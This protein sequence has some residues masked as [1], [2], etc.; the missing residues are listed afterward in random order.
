MPTINPTLVP[1]IAPGSLFDKLT[2]DDTFNIRWLTN[3]DP[4]FFGVLNRP[5]ADTVLRTLILAKAI[6]QLNVSLGHSAFFPFLIQPR[7]A[8]GSGDVD[9]PFNWLWDI[10]MS[11]PAKWANVRL[12]K[13]KR[14][15][16]SNE[17]SS[18][19]TGRL[20]L[21]FT[22][23]QT[24]STTETALVYV[25]YDI[26]SSRTYQIVRVAPVGVNEEATHIEENEFDTVT[27]FVT[28]K[29]LDTSDTIVQN[30][31]NL[32]EPPL[33]TDDLDNN[34]FF[35]SPAVYELVDA[36]P[37]DVSGDF[38]ATSVSH[39]TGML[40]I[41]AFNAIP[42]LDSDIQSWVNSFNYPYDATANR[43]STTNIVMPI[44]LFREFDISVPAGD[45]PTGDV[46]GS[47]YP[48]WV[49]RI[50]RINNTATQLRFYFATYNVTDAVSGGTP[51]TEPIEFATLDLNRDMTA[52]EIVEIVPSTNLQLQTGTDADQWGQHL[53][54]GHVVLSTLW[55]G[56]TNEVDNFFDEFGLITD[57][58]ADTEFS[59]SSTRISSFG[60]SRV[61]KYT[62]TIGQAQAL[63]GSSARFLPPINP[64]FNNRFITEADQGQG[65][66]INLEAEAGIIPH[67]AI[68]PIGYSGALAHRCVQMIV[69]STKVGDADPDLFYENEVNPRLAILFGRDP[70]FGDM[71]HNGTRVMF[72]NGDTWQSM[73]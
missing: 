63:L 15:S 28:F 36:S 66:A 22:G 24:G 53:G 51:S 16:G 64:S 5:I 73:G 40:G 62:P 3:K 68:K 60:L 13:V 58:P 54:R 55:G 35:D 46:S 67:I 45:E 59:K 8:A 41:G 11:F 47:F 19:Y 32:V 4:A 33:D 31:L 42:S 14:I 20:R 71:W 43:T 49:A 2:T 10:N 69:D 72:H 17:G 52:G 38:S 57:S 18:G 21:I 70:R 9:V 29:T 65:N 50:E 27:G 26:T 1:T 6:D 34:G 48:V 23:V 30:F 25:D 37:G 56:T 44:G 61:P 7:I 39:G 12:A